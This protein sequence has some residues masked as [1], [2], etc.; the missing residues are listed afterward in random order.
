MTVP[1][2]SPAAFPTLSQPLDL[3]VAQLVQE[4]LHVAG[5]PGDQGDQL[6]I[7]TTEVCSVLIHNYLRKPPVNPLQPEHGDEIGMR[8]RHCVAGRPGSEVICRDAGARE[9]LDEVVVNPLV[10]NVVIF[11]RGPFYVIVLHEGGGCQLFIIGHIDCLFDALPA[12]G[13]KEFPGQKRVR[14]E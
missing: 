3:V 5:N 8:A 10:E 11:I 13:V 14:E 7:R 2:I 1:E 4:G 6:G 12:I 9:V